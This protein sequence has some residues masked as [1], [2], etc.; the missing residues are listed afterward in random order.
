M[1]FLQQLLFL[2]V[3]L[4]QLLNLRLA[5]LNKLVVKLGGL[6]A[7]IGGGRCCG[8]G[9]VRGGIQLLVVHS[10]VPLTLGDGIIHLL[11]RCGELFILLGAVGGL[12]TIFLQYAE[13]FLGQFNVLCIHL[14]LHGLRLFKELLLFSDI[15][16]R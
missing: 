4:G 16:R 2:L 11:L 7:V 12:F 8:L 6:L 1:I 9:L 10:L 15:F 14:G 3:L 13:L 5:V